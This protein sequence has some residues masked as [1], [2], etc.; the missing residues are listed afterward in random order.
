MNNLGK[1]R[2]FPEDTARLGKYRMGRS[3]CIGFK[4]NKAEVSAR[5]YFL[6]RRVVSKQSDLKK[7]E[8]EYQTPMR[9]N[10]EQ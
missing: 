7:K 9:V 8:P 1:R 6:Q 5:G 4:G 10:I 3:G 2:L